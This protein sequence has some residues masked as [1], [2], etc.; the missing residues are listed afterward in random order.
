MLLN[1]LKPI[2]MSILRND[3]MLDMN[4]EDQEVSLSQIEI[5]T[6]SC[7]FGAATSS[8]TRLHRYILNNTGN[9]KFIQMVSQ[10]ILIILGK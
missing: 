1:H 9:H 8:V 4:K 5:N 10:F 3:F 2:S 7:S 6:V